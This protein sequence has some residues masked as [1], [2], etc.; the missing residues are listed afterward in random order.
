MKPDDVLNFWAGVGNE[1]WWKRNDDLKA[2]RERELATNQKLK[3]EVHKYQ[4]QYLGVAECRLELQ[5][6]VASMLTLIQDSCD[7]SDLIRHCFNV[8]H[9]CEEDSKFQM[10]SLDKV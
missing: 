7:D 6:A 3:A 2:E 4:Q 8:A 10:S 9:D 5:K 1:G